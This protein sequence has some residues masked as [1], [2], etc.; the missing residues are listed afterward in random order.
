M[1]RLGLSGRL[2]RIAH[3]SF[4][5]SEWTNMKWL[6]RRYKMTLGRSDVIAL[7]S[8]TGKQIIFVFAEDEVSYQDGHDEKQLTSVL[9][10]TRHRIIGGGTWSP[11]MLVNYARKAGIE[12]IGLKS[13]EQYFDEQG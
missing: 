6:I 12:L 3:V 9:T 4:C 1:A 8:M 11:K 10:S 13:F 5:C 2:R 7:I